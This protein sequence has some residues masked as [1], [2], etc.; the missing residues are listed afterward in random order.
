[1]KI[2]DIKDMIQEKF[3]KVLSNTDD[4]PDPESTDNTDE[5]NTEEKNFDEGISSEEEDSEL[6]PQAQKTARK[7]LKTEGDRGE[8]LSEVYINKYLEVK[9][10]TPPEEYDDNRAR[11]IARRAYL[12]Y[13]NNNP[14][15]DQE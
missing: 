8:E 9:E 13:K 10:T 6:S 11:S 3:N 15:G 5:A 7:I 14:S 4:T 1:M 2:I 12:D